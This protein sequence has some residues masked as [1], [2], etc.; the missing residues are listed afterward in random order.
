MGP[1]ITYPVPPAPPRPDS[2]GSKVPDLLSGFLCVRPPGVLPARRRPCRPPPQGSGA[3]GQ[4][5]G[6]KAKAT[7]FTLTDVRR[8]TWAAASSPPEGGLVL[9]L[10]TCGLG[11]G[12]PA[13][14]WTQVT[15]NGDRCES[16]PS[17]PAHS[18][19]APQPH[20]GAT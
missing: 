2:T 11:S 14:P 9:T 7:A 12:P 18:H 8:S 15:V 16:P 4:H 20:D 10:L 3:G 17:G 6:I 5:P 1:E 13:P 19:P